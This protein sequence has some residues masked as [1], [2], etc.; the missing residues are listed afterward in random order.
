MFFERLTAFLCVFFF[1][2]IR[3]GSNIVCNIDDVCRRLL[4]QTSRFQSI[5]VM[6][7]NAVENIRLVPDS[8]QLFITALAVRTAFAG[9]VQDFSQIVYQCTVDGI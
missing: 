7:P 2:P 8:S 4:G 3:G 9:A 6:I 5:C 1:P